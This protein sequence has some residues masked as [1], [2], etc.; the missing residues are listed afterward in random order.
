M[1]RMSVRTSRARQVGRTGCAPRGAG[2]GR[3]DIA[4]V[5]CRMP[6]LWLEKVERGPSPRPVE[7]GACCAVAAHVHPVSALAS[8]SCLG[9]S[10][11]S[12]SGY[13]A[14]IYIIRNDPY[15]SIRAH[16][17]CHRHGGRGRVQPAAPVVNA[18]EVRQVACDSRATVSTR[19]FSFWS[20]PDRLLATLKVRYG[21]PPGG[22]RV[23]L[24]AAPAGFLH[25]LRL[26]EVRDRLSIPRR[27]V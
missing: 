26:Q 5:A 25:P 10:A 16:R 4:R 18:R 8:V 13:H 14:L 12:N 27:H 24:K 6:E 17:R 15:G 11:C 9:R 3:T 19:P 7:R 20:L 1:L 21:S 2:A 23:S 22:R